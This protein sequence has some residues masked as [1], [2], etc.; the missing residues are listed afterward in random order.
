MGAG[1]I[2]RIIILFTVLLF[3]GLSVHAQDYTRPITDQMPVPVSQDKKISLSFSVGAAVPLRNFGSNKINGFWGN[4]ANDSTTLQGFAKTGFHFEI[5]GSYLFSDEVGIRAVFGS[6]SNSFDETSF[7]SASGVINTTASGNYNVDEFLIGPYL[8]FSI[9]TKVRV[10]IGALIG[11]VN[12]SYP[13]IY[14]TVNDTLSDEW[15]FKGGVNFGYS[16]FAEIEYSISSNIGI[17]INASYTGSDITYN[18]WTWSG[19]S[20]NYTY[21]YIGPTFQTNMQT[22]LLKISTGLVV[23]F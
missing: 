22:G 17:L 15:G 18:S 1:N 10:N 5:A 19:T 14:Q 8:S 20:T 16:A 6:S 7:S 21:T 3:T 11:I 9:G 13:D 2:R 23:K 4:N 12:I